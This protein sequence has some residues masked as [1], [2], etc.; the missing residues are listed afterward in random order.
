MQV[1]AAGN[2]R[3]GFGIGCR[4]SVGQSELGVA[5]LLKATWQDLCLASLLKDLLLILLGRLFRIDVM[6]L[7]GV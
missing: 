3:W 4:G 6:T 2:A 7:E 1:A 5:A